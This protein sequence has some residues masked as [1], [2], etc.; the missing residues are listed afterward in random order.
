MNWK[1]FA[2]LWS[3]GLPG[4]V[5]L[6]WV[7]VPALPSA[8][9]LPA[10]PS[11]IMVVSAL[12]SALLLAMAVFTGC[13]LAPRIGLQAPLSS[14]WLSGAPLRHILRAQLPAAGAGGL[15]GIAILWGYTEFMPAA[16]EESGP[17]PL[18]VRVLY[19]GINEELLLRWGLMSLLAW[20][21]WRVCQRGEGALSPAMAWTAIIASAVVF[22]I[23]H[24]PAASALL[25]GLNLPLM[26]YI[27][28]AN[29]AFGLVAGYLFWKRGLEAAI[30]AHGFAHAGFFMISGR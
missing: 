6:V 25:G 13:R 1:L 4:I 16:L 29:A 18:I 15:L 23:G 5:A 26:L 28:A 17:L 8:Q 2:L 19:G 30:L 9:P 27:I 14:A 22:G 21:L 11:V 3:A 12:Q 20:L 24:L 7:I 10:P